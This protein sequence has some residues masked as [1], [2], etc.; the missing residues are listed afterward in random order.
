MDNSLTDGLATNADSLASNADGPASNADGPATNAGSPATST[1]GLATNAGSLATNADGLGRAVERYLRRTGHAA[2]RPEAVLFDM[3]GVLFD[4]M[5]AHAESWSQVCDTFGLRLSPEEVYMNEGRT[6]EATIGLLMR[7]QWGREP[8]AAEMRDIYAA[9]CAAF[10]CHPE[11]KAMPGA[12]EALAAV[13]REGMQ[14]LVVTGS[15]Q[16]SLL[17]RLEAH[18]PGCFPAERVVSSRDVVRGKPDPEP[19][20]RGL[21]KAGGLEAWRALVVENAPLGVQAAVAAGV[22]TIAV[23]TGPL[24]DK[25]LLDAGADL[26][27]PSMTA[28]AEAFPRICAAIAAAG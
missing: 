28:L 23:N 20:L 10:N 7:R 9:K 12:I 17:A 16:E 18:F 8:T 25:A 22:F 6:G 19:Y 21:E 26:L 1:D 3:D 11:A 13:R 14:T 2:L 27:L 4:S 24:P 5:P 15:G